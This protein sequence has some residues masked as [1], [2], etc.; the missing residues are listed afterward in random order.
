MRGIQLGF[1]FAHT[2]QDRLAAGEQRRPDFFESGLL[3][4]EVSPRASARNQYHGDDHPSSYQIRR[5]TAAAG[6]DK[7]IALGNRRN[8][9]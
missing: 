9:E 4:A 6:E 2:E 1:G 3:F 8:G 5:P 7:P